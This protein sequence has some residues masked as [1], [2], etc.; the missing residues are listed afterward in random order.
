[1]IYTVLIMP[2]AEQELEDA[3]DWLAAQSPLHAPE[4]HNGLVDAIL[5]LENSPARCPLAPEADTHEQTRQLLYGNRQ[6]AYRILFK[7]RDQTVLVLHIIHAA[8]AGS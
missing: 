4:W 2:A 7:I 5:S 1:M 3:Y 8:R 6:H